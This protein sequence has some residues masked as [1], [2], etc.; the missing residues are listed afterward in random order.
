MFEDELKDSVFMLLI[1]LQLTD[2]VFP[3]QIVI[4]WYSTNSIKQLCF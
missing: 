3:S 1:D 4:F 2:N